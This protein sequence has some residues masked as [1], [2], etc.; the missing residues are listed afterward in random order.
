MVADLAL[1]LRILA[2]CQMARLQEKE[3]AKTGSQDGPKQSF[4]LAHIFLHLVFIQLIGTLGMTRET[5]STSA[6]IVVDNF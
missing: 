2:A 5:H 3:N 6:C 1:G 4:F